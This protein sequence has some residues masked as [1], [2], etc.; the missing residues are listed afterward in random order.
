MNLPEGEGFYRISPDL[1]YKG[2]MK[3]G[4]PNGNG[5]I[6]CISTQSII[7]QGSVKDGQYQGQGC[8]YRD[9]YLYEK[10]EFINGH[11]KEGIRYNSNGTIYSGSFE[12]DLFDGEGRVVFTN[13]FFYKAKFKAGVIDSPNVEIAYPSARNA[14]SVPSTHITIT[15]DSLMYSIGGNFLVFY[16]NGDI[17]FGHME[18]SIPREGYLHRFVKNTFVTMKVG[19]AKGVPATPPSITVLEGGKYKT[20]S[21]MPM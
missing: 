7:Y 13:G 14:T 4:L 9:G 8:L 18:A 15:E 1:V 12:K 20:F 19:S 6:I 3:N 11:I 17:F 16:T 21:M 10:G 5:D 2:A